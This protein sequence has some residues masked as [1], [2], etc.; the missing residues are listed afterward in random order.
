MPQTLSPALAALPELAGAALAERAR[1]YSTA[2]ARTA[3]SLKTHSWS[4]LPVQNLPRTW[5]MDG[6]TRSA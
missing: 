1:R 4:I 2:Q 3:G 6:S 5:M